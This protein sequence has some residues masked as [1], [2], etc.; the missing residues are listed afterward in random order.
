ME[1]WRGSGRGA[2][3]GWWRW[4]WLGWRD[5]GGSQTDGRVAVGGE[6]SY[7]VCAGGGRISTHSGQ[8]ILSKAV[9]QSSQRFADRS[10]MKRTL[11]SSPDRPVPD[12]R[13]LL[14]D[15]QQSIEPTLQRM[16]SPYCSAPLVEATGGELQCSSAGSLFSIS[17]REQF[18]KLRLE[19]P[20][21]PCELTR[22][23]LGRWF[24]PCCGKATNNGVCAKCGPVITSRL[25]RQLLEL[26]P[27]ERNQISRQ[28]DDRQSGPASASFGRSRS[29]RELP[30]IV[31]T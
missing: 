28:N 18:E 13:H 26:N 22:F 24:C 3:R 11:T 25:A 10:T 7:D 1:L 14:Q 4:R 17:V 20:V 19:V 9:S 21:L 31:S 27:H 15:R 30:T 6:A 2:R 5:A 29:I 8:T 23:N 16:H 12:A